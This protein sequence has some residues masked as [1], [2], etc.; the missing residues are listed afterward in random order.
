MNGK[1]DLWEK[2]K[3]TTFINLRGSINLQRSQRK[4][5]LGEWGS[6]G[7]KTNESSVKEVEW[8]NKKILI[9]FPSTEKSHLI[10]IFFIQ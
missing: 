3:K 4:K 5:S 9:L 1:K 10:S 7:A 2:K 6:R 8:T